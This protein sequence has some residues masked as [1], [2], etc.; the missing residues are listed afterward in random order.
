MGGMV[1]LGTLGGD[2]SE[3]VGVDAGGQVI[4]NSNNTANG[5]FHAFSW[6]AAEGM[7]D[8]GTLGG[9]I[10]AAVAVNASGQVIGSS[11]TAGGVEPPFHA[12]SWAAA[13]GMVDLGTLGGDFS[14][15]VA[16]N[17]RGQV[18][19]LSQTA[20]GSNHTF[21]WTA[22]GGIVALDLGSLGGGSNDQLIAINNTG[23]IV[24]ASEL[25]DG[26]FHA[27]LWQV[28]RPPDCGMARPD[29]PV[30][31]PP[32]HKLVPIH[33]VGI[34]DPDNHPLA[35]T[36]T[37]VTQ[38]EPVNGRGDGNTSPDAVLQENGV[39]LRAERAGAGNGRIY[40]IN[41]RADDGF[42]GVCTGSVSVVVPKS[43]KSRRRH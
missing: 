3:A 39:L 13:G 36:I 30:L 16:V 41:F 24:G 9:T 22:T 2:F 35:I 8:L 18:I 34:S 7:V 42:G 11:A 28:S 21:L 43:M 17:D 19:G 38:D 32:N 14:E 20:D 40:R 15:A 33:I 29:V 27:T 10:S 37:G 6:T 23:I 5:V 1:D 25:A 12:F 4:G 31:W 26:V